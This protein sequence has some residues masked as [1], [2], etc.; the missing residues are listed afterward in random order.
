MKSSEERLAIKA[1][2]N[3]QEIPKKI[4]PY[5][6][7]YK[8][9]DI[10]STFVIGYDDIYQLQDVQFSLMEKTQFTYASFE[11]PYEVTELWKNEKENT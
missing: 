10:N 2:L 3:P 9:K 6:L 4:Y 1:K 5:Y 8:Y 7:M 11:Y